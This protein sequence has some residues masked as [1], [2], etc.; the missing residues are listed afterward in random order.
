MKRQPVVLVTGNDLAPQALELLKD[1]EVRFA[2]KSCTEDVLLALAKETDPVAIIVRYGRIGASI[3]D[4]AP[5]LK[6]ISKHGSG[7]DVIDQ[8]AA[9]ER[10]IAV[11]AAVGANAAAV[12]EHAWA[13]ILACAKSVPHLNGRTREGYWDKSIH[14]SIELNGRTL[15]IVGLGEIGRRVAVTGVALGMRVI[16][17]DPYANAVPDG[18]ELVNDLHDIYRNADVVS[19]HCPLTESNRGMLNRETLGLFKNGAILINTARGGLIDEPAL[20]DALT[21]GKLYASGLDSFAIEPMTVPH[22]FRQ[23]PNAILTPHIGGVSDAAYI[24]MG[25]GAATNVLAVLGSVTADG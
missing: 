11:K 16:A 18:V 22:P 24:S 10:G 4:A 17:F 21:N 2:G 6:V 3:M 7:I 9:A 23:I 19:L 8:K 12:A 15:G 13:L 14:K 20:A 5:S 1:F 25:V